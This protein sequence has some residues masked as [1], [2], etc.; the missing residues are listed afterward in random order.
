[1]KPTDHL[2]TP[3]TASHPTMGGLQRPLNRR[4]L[5]K[6]AAALSSVLGT[7]ALLTACGQDSAPA[8]AGAVDTPPDPIIVC[9][10]RAQLSHQTAFS[11]RLPTV[12]GTCGA[13]GTPSVTTR[14]GVA[15][16]PVVGADDA[17]GGAK[18][19]GMIRLRRQ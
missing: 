4:Q 7:P 3:A 1:M 11:T 13:T 19:G 16:A 9:S 18:L 10:P 5:L 2:P 15:A 8:A 17:L 6:Q 12:I 14:A